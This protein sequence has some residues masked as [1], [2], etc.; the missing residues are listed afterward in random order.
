MALFDSSGSY[1]YVLEVA[2]DP[3]CFVANKAAIDDIFQSLTMKAIK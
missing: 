3:D 2:C 1:L